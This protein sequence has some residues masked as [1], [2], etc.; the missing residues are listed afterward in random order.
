MIQNV[1]VAQSTWAGLPQRFEA[2]T[3]NVAGAVGL[4]AALEYYTTHRKEALKREQELTLAADAIIRRY[5][6]V[7]GPAKRSAP[8]ISFIVPGA[9]AHDVAQLLDSYGVCVRA[10]HHCCQPLHDALSVEASV[11]V[12][13]ALYNTNEDLIKLEQGLAQVRK[14]FG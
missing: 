6:R 2:G 10:G 14:V 7:I 5:A 4:A 13:L 1:T 12:S 9:H 8:I 3:P 11:R